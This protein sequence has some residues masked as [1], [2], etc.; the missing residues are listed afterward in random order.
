MNV[1]EMQEH[2]FDKLQQMLDQRLIKGTYVNGT[3][4]TI[5]STVLNMKKEV[6]RLVQGFDFTRKNPKVVVINTKDQLPSLEDAIMLTFLNKLGFD[7]VLFVPTGYQM[8]E[9]YLNDNYPVEHQIGEY[10]YDLSVP[11]FS[12]LSPLKGPS[13]LKNLFR[14]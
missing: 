7:I 5:L 4:Y 14:R 3:E 8:I 9:R 2:I 13:R 11:D 1:E 12:Q 10:V 6:L